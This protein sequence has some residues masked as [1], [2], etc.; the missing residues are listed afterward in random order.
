[1]IRRVFLGLFGLLVLLVVVIIGRALMVGSSRQPEGA[2]PPVDHA[3]ATLIA[4]R[5]ADAV[6]FQTV[7]LADSDK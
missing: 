3:A 1:M 2:A 4:Q 5:L 6:H 7:S